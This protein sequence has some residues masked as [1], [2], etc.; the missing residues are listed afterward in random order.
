MR[1]ANADKDVEKLNHPALVGMSVVQPVWKTDGQF[2]YKN[3]NMKL[4]CDPA[5]ATLGIYP[6][7]MKMYVYT[8]TYLQIF[9][10]AYA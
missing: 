4:P 7:E 5:V 9:I 6:R 1:A 2:L 10:A 8:K 3:L